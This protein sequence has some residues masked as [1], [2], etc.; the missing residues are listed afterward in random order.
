MLIL[1][2]AKLI[3]ISWVKLSA[4]TAS[5]SILLFPV[6]G[7][8]KRKVW[9]IFIWDCSVCFLS[10]SSISLPW[11]VI[12]PVSLPHSVTAKAFLVQGSDVLSV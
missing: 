3:I 7:Q 12:P 2:D 10:P 9:L 4:A 11:L 1:L 8:K 6:K 5:I